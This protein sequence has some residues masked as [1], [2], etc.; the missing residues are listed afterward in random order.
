MK[1]ILKYLIGFLKPKSRK[2]SLTRLNA[3]E[4]IVEPMGGPVGQLFY[5]DFAIMR[6]M[7]K[8]QKVPLQYLEPEPLISIE[9]FEEMELQEKNN[10]TKFPTPTMSI[11]HLTGHLF[12]G[13][14]LGNDYYQ[15]WCGTTI[16][17]TSTNMEKEEEVLDP[18]PLKHFILK[19]FSWVKDV[20]VDAFSS[21]SKSKRKVCV[22][23]T[24]SPT[25]YSELMDEGIER[26]VRER[27]H[28]L[29]TP[30]VTCIYT[31]HNEN[32]PI[33]V[34]QPEKSET[35]LDLL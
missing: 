29:I 33:I 5:F 34:F 32:L 35:I 3:T 1:R 13:G 4:V 9:K 11:G 14:T 2:K 20:G 24:V 8:P 16:N 22:I 28:K 17:Q 23:L 6:G 10:L 19:E 30:L 15:R 7:E 25:H 18:T 31:E 27:L 21:I 12:S 26:K